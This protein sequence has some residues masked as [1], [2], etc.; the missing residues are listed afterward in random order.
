MSESGGRINPTISVLREAFPRFSDR[1]EKHVALWRGEP[2]GSYNDMAEFVR[3]V[4]EDLYEKGDV[5]ETRR[6]FELM[7]KLL[8]GANEDTRG[9]IAFGFFENLQN[10]ASWR[11]G[12]NKVY[13]Q[14]FGPL[15]LQIWS[16]LRAM[17]RGKS[18]LM[19]VIR[20]ER[21]APKP[22]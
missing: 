13:A 16:E 21:K 8:A 10:C 1:W 22:H 15:S 4:V 18:S 20:A 6:F 12:G 9:L 5:D 11:P 19:D 3:F 2:A 7:E 14:F 17:W